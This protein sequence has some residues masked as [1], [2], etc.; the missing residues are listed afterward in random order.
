ARHVVTE[1]A[2]VLR[3]VAALEADDFAELGDLLRASHASLR[4]DYAVSVP[5]LDLLVELA[6]AEPD[7]WGARLTGGG[8]GG[9]ILVAARAGSGAAIG[10]RIATAY[11]ARTGRTATVRV[12]EVRR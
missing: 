4:D 11:R 10:E 6:G 3:A 2:R 12:P 5:E 1:N 8:F 9:S 7:A